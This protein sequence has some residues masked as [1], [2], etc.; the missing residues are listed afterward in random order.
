M[1]T[2]PEN[3]EETGSEKVRSNLL[4][5]LQHSLGVDQYGRGNQYRNYFVT[6]EGSTDFPLCSELV[7]MG[8]M[9]D[10]GTQS[11]CGG[12]HVFH[13]TEAGK[14]AVREFSPAPP[15]LNRAQR[16]YQAFL[17]ADCGMT[18]GQYL[19]ACHS[20]GLKA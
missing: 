10:R 6:G 13:V 3:Y 12:D 11:M 16:R 15:K 19:K 8:L 7:A 4:H 18:F 17:R 9:Q 20:I 5:I 14:A 1:N 2:K